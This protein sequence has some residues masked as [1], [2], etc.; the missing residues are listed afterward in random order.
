MN[1]GIRS[2]IFAVALML[3]VAC[4]RPGSGVAGT[5]AVDRAVAVARA[6]RADPPAT[7][8]ILAAHDFT[9]AEFDALLY[10]VAADSALARVYTGAIQ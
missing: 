5:T 3:A 8:S 7:D 10:H 1:T 6:V 4:G 2:M 9:R